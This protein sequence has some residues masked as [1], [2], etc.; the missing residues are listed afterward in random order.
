MSDPGSPLDTP[1]AQRALLHHGLWPIGHRNTKQSYETAAELA[2]A[3]YWDPA[4]VWAVRAG[5]ILVREVLLFP[6]Y[7]MQTG[8]VSASFSRVADTFGSGKW[9]RSLRIA[10]EGHG[11]DDEP[12]TDTD[13]DAWDHWRRWAV[14]MRADIVHGR[15][16]LDDD[17]HARWTIDY[18]ERMHTWWSMRIITADTGPMVGLAED[19]TRR[20]R[21]IYKNSRTQDTQPGEPE[22][23]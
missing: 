18:V 15:A 14:S 16:T 17:Y 23:D 9:K 2:D 22:D 6:I 21:E 1:E 5:E 12:L 3:G 8:D 20:M 19:I 4:L 10:H 13:E 11:I 7:F